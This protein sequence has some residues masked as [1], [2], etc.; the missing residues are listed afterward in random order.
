MSQKASRERAA[1]SLWLLGQEQ[2]VSFPAI[3]KTSMV[4]SNVLTQVDQPRLAQDA[5]QASTLNCGAAR[6]P[7][8]ENSTWTQG[9]SGGVSSDSDRGYAQGCKPDPH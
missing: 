6:S 2:G 5:T 3:H 7:W 9:D 4:L 1:E 8:P